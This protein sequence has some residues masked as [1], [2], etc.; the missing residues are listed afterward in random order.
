MKPVA[1][2][3]DHIIVIVIIGW[4]AWLFGQ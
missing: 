4:P 2:D 3:A 1:A